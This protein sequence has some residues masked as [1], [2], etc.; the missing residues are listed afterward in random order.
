MFRG[1]R[2]PA[3][4]PCPSS[5]L[6]GLSTVPGLL[7]LGPEGGSEASSTTWPPGAGERAGAATPLTHVSPN[8]CEILGSPALEPGEGLRL[9]QVATAVTPPSLSCPSSLPGG[10][11]ALLIP[12]DFSPTNLEPILRGS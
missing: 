3:V 12:T 6:P 4:P 1:F 10:F 9:N 5:A 7:V 11:Q 2:A 8:D